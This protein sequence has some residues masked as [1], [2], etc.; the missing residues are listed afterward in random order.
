MPEQVRR[1]TERVT[2]AYERTNSELVTAR[3]QIAEQQQLL[4]IRRQRKKGKRIALKGRFVF[5]TEEV[6]EIAQA[7]EAETAAKKAKKQPRKRATKQSKVQEA[8]PVQ[9]SS[10]G[11]SESDCIVVEACT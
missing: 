6:L 7:A 11:S 8:E 10:S 2:K 5:S 9:E 4:R 1:Y 3:K